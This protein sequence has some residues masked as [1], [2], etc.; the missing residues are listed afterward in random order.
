MTGTGSGTFEFWWNR[1]G[2]VGEIVRDAHSLY[3]QTLGELG[4]VGLALLVA[5]LLTVV[6]GGAT[7]ALRAD[8]AE[9]SLR[10]AALAGC[11]AFALTAGF[12]WTWQIP[13]IPVATLLCAAALVESLPPAPRREPESLALPLRGAVALVAIAAI[14]AMAIP[15][16]A[17]A[18]VRQSEADAREGDLVAALEA[19]KSAQNVQ[20]S[21]ATPR[22]QQALVLEQLGDLDAAARAA[23]EAT[24]REETNWRPWLV[25]SRIEAARGRAGAAVWAYRRARSLNPRSS[26]FAR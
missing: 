25:L 7:V 26:L 3:M 23:S 14:V 6:I 5:F 20:P 17:T 19:A 15:L 22:L 11:G 1:D 10:A 24:D 8:A 13:V 18:L 12:D 16:A 9:R 21:A 4:I 2:D